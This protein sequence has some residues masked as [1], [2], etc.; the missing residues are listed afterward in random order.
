M[1]K[2]LLL[3][4][5]LGLAVLGAPA[6]AQLFEDDRPL[7]EIDRALFELEDTIHR[8][9]DPDHADKAED[10]MAKLENAGREL[11]KHPPD[12]QAAAGSLEGAIGDLEASVRDKCFDPATGIGVMDDLAEISRQLATST[13]DAAYGY[14]GKRDEI[15]DAQD[16][17]A[18]GDALRAS[19]RRGNLGAFKQAANKYKDALSKAESAIQ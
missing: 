14:R 7:R 16:A 8:S 19:G 17:L 11:A 10:A 15:H 5:L 1:R 12:D 6:Q 13:L 2:D 3:T 9:C 4:G 18:R